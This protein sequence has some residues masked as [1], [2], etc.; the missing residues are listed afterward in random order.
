MKIWLLRYTKRHERVDLLPDPR[1]FIPAVML[2]A[3]LVAAVCGAQPV[4]TLDQWADAIYKAECGTGPK[5]TC[6]YLYGIR[7]VKYK[8]EAEARRICINTVRKT[9][10]KYRSTRCKPGQSDI[11]CLSNR[12]CPIGSDTDNGTCKYW[13]KNVL[14]FLNKE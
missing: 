11:D 9:L 2:C 1:W 3:L 13:K 8:D 7:S 6:T 12:Y 5:P 4:Y 14:S 10:F